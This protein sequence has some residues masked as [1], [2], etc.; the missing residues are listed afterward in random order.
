M[1]EVT[2]NLVPLGY[3]TC[4]KSKYQKHSDKKNL[5]QAVAGDAAV[6]FTE[7]GINSSVTSFLAL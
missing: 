7:E 6:A 2:R 5:I 1:Q 4:K 3:I